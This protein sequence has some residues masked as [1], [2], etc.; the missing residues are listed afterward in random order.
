MKTPG[1]IR[2]ILGIALAVLCLNTLSASLM[3]LRYVLDSELGFVIR[4]GIWHWRVE[5]FGTIHRL[6]RGI[7]DN[8]VATQT[9]PK[10]LILG[11]SVVEALEVDDL[12]AF[13]SIIQRDLQRSGW[14]VQL[15]N[16][17]C[18]G[19][20]VADY[21]NLAP[22]LLGEFK[23]N[24]TVI[25]LQD[26]DWEE[27]AWDVAKR[28]FVKGK[29]ANLTVMAGVPRVRNRIRGYLSRRF[30]LEPLNELCE[31]R[32]R[33]LATRWDTEPALFAAADRRPQ[34]RKL[35]YPIEQE[36]DL[37]RT[38]YPGG[39]SLLYLAKFQVSGSQTAVSPLQSR[40]QKLCERNQVDYIDFS[41][42]FPQLRE[43]GQHP[44]GFPNTSYGAGHFNIYGH[45]AL[46]RCLQ[47]RLLSLHRAG[48]V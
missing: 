21:V 12:E 30:K 36:F 48:K 2:T 11:D 34:G 15:L 33:L 46:A 14:D 37:L 47:A 27:D 41:T 38:A 45:Q 25:V 10:L 19:R 17:G 7:R 4:E 20:S 8:G 39:L 1:W 28:H 29:D 13:P 6:K 23:P 5:G 31:I 22:P 24:W 44:Q 32:S 9:G 16:A 42:E 3:N 40:I 35:E 26:N 18:G 43:L